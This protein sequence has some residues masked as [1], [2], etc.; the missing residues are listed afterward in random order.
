MFSVPSLPGKNRGEH[1]EEFESRSVKT[2]E[3]FESFHLL[4]NSHKLCR[5]F[6][7]AMKVRKT[8]FI[9]FIQNNNFPTQ[10]RKK[11]YMKCLCNFIS[12]K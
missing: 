8:G 12:F 6:H 1:L 9:S 3:A 2:R 4:D 5:G 10:Q 7:H 11:R